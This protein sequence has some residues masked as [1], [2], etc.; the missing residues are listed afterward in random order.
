MDD[1]HGDFGFGDGN[2][3]E[4]SLLDFAKAFELVIGRSI[5]ACEVLY[6]AGYSNIF[7]VQGG[8]EAAEEEDLE[9][10]G[11]QPFKFA[12]IGGLSEFLGVVYPYTGPRTGP[13]APYSVSAHNDMR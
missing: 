13:A 11:P 7:W 6:N 12:G 1:V 3:G 8:L 9:R 2:D 5:A 10:E 4:V